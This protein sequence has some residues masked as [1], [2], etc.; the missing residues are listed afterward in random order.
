MHHKVAT[1]VLASLISRNAVALGFAPPSAA[2]SRSAFRAVA[3]APRGPPSRRA[4]RV[5]SSALNMA[6]PK[7]GVS[8]P[9]EI[10]AFVESAGSGLVVSDVRNPDASVEPG[11]QKSLTVAPL[12]SEGF[13]PLAQHLIYDRTTES[14]P[15]PV[16]DGIEKGTPM[17]THCGGGGRG[18]KA[19]DYLESKGYT[20]VINGGG[21]KETEC[22][23]EFGDK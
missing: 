8:S 22:W 13:R 4:F 16:G 9:E 19:K 12:P 15:L 1:I 23:A 20:N 5:S 7:A 17:I 14:M 2:L 11:D 3:G 6:P 18:Q 21:P 10:R